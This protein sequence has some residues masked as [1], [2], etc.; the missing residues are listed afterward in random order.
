MI[1]IGVGDGI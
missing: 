1:P